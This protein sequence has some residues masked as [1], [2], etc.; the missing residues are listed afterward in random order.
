[1]QNERPE[2]TTIGLRPAAAC[3]ALG[4]SRRTLCA[5]T[6]DRTL[7]LPHC[8]IGKVILYPERELRDWLAARMERP[9]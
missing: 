8:R 9:R 7:G 5:W 4:V 6:S 3:R 1:M 2:T